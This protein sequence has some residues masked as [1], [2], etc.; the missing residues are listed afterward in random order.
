MAVPPKRTP[1]PVQRD[2][3]PKL[4]P[5]QSDYEDLDGKSNGSEG[6]TALPDIMR[7]YQCQHCGSTFIS[8]GKCTQCGA[9]N[10]KETT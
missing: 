3:V 2:N 8:L 10:M 4:Y 6:C 1:A 9:H 7:T 5:D